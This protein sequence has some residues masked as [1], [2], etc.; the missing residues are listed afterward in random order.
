MVSAADV[1]AR[2]Q[3]VLGRPPRPEEIDEFTGSSTCQL[4]HTLLRTWQQTYA[5][6][7]LAT[8]PPR[9]DLVPVLM[10]MRNDEYYIEH[11][12][13]HLMER[14]T[15]TLHEWQMWPHFYMFENDSSDA[16]PKLLTEIATGRDNVTLVSERLNHLAP[17]NATERSSARAGRIA[18][19]RNSLVGLALTDIQRSRISI[20]IDTNV[21]F[22]QATLNALTA[23][24]MDKKTAH[25]GLALAMTESYD[26]PNHYYDTY[27]YTCLQDADRLFGLRRKACPVIECLKCRTPRPSRPVN[28]LRPMS[29]K[30]KVLH[31][32]ASAFGGLG[33]FDSRVLERIYWS[34]ERDLCEHVAMCQRVRRLNRSVVIVP[35]AR[36]M[37]AQNLSES[38]RR[39]FRDKLGLPRIKKT[40]TVVKKY[41]GWYG[42]SRPMGTTRMGQTIHNIHNGRTGGQFGQFGQSDRIVPSRTVPDR[43]VPSRPVPDRIQ[44]V[45]QPVRA[46]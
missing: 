39:I 16:T 41:V 17:K 45:V 4:N 9:P 8:K 42:Q 24:M 43:T 30:Q 19:Y 33:V 25:V 5:G 18:F 34:S 37:W 21:I 12:L 7:I 10:L 11:F 46:V 38:A 29:K 40:S 35:W 36:A 13:P 20:M 23:V 1:M 31:E 32:V 26:V 14:I 28:T 2:F 44:R 3:A 27:A 6:P 15:K 22:D